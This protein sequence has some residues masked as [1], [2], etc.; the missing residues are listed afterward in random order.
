MSSEQAIN[1][2]RCSRVFLLHLLCC[3]WWWRSLPSCGN[4]AL[5]CLDKRVGLFL[6]DDLLAGLDTEGQALACHFTCLFVLL[7][8][9]QFLDF[10]LDLGL[11]LQH[12]WFDLGLYLL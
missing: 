5:N 12:L 9:H 7:G 11:Q 2:F 8:L 10:W 6:A 1:N 3:L 4:T